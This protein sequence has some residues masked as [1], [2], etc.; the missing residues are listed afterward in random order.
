MPFTFGSGMSQIANSGFSTAGNSAS[1]SGF[2]GTLGKAIE[3]SAIA[4]GLI[5]LAS[6]RGSALPSSLRVACDAE[7]LPWIS[8]RPFVAARTF[9]NPFAVASFSESLLP[10]IRIKTANGKIVSASEGR[11][12]DAETFIVKFELK[13][14]LRWRGVLPEVLPY[15][16]PWA[17]VSEVIPDAATVDFIRRKHYQVADV[18]ARESENLEFNILVGNATSEYHIRRTMQ[19][20]SK[21]C[22]PADA[23]FSSI[24]LTDE[25]KRVCQLVSSFTSEAWFRIAA[26]RIFIG[27]TS[28]HFSNVLVSKDGSLILID[29]DSARFESGKDLEML[30]RFVRR[31]SRVFDLLGEVAA[32]TDGDIRA[33]VA[34]IPKRPACGPVE[35]LAPYFCERLALWKAL[36]AGRP[37]PERTVAQAAV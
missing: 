4:I 7:L 15:L 13:E 28:P 24:K 2:W 8:N 14:R 19:L 23:L 25:Q 29:H 37:A 22:R 1:P 26:A 16:G 18:S 34:A 9:I 10:K 17:Y 6:W 36:H 21:K 5:V 3:D 35:S 27:C 30:F 31:G 11:K 33:A 12:L 32:L 20:V